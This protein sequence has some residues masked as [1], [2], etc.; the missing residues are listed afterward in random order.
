[1]FDES[2][3]KENK[4]AIISTPGPSSHPNPLHILI[5]IFKT[6]THLILLSLSREQNKNKK[7]KKNYVSVQE[8]DEI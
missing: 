6:H 7:H 1:V 4:K 5:S 8:K 2:P 3:I